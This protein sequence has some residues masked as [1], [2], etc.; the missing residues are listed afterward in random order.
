MR[1]LVWS[2]LT[3]AAAMGQLPVVVQNEWVRVVKAANAPGQLSR[4]HVHLI[5]RVMIHLDK[6]VLRIDNK[7]TGV[8][9]DIPFRAGEVRFDPRVGLHTSE[10]VGGSPIRIVEVELNDHPPGQHPAKLKSPGRRF[11]VDMENVQVRILRT[12]MTPGEELGRAHFRTP[13]VAV[14][15]RDGHTVFGQAVRN[16][17]EAGEWVVVELK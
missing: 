9:R 7:D 1:I 15:L 6:G 17:G 8:T 5:N 11:Q 13:V 4:P 14:R 10:N 2:V 12:Q 16:D 3:M